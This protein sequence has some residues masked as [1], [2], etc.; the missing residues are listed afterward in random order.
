M[1][2]VN[3]TYTTFD[4]FGNANSALALNGGYN[5]IPS[6]IYLNTQEFSIWAWV[7]PQ[8]LTKWSRIIELGNGKALDIIIFALSYDNTTRPYFDIWDGNTKLFTEKTNQ[9]VF[10]NEWQLL[11]ATFNG[12]NARIYLN[13]TLLA[14]MPTSYSMTNVYR[15]RSFVGYSNWN[16]SE[17]YSFID[18]LRFYKKALTRPEI[19]HLMNQS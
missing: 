14:D 9:T 10:M 7:F 4:R 18:D 8:N 12:T 19:I 13:E 17:S 1:I 3:L 16:S 15:T 11:V 6:G 5:L 2:N